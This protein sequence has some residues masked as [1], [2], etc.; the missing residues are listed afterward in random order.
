MKKVGLYVRVSTREQAEEG[1]SV[2]AQIDKLRLYCQSKDWMVVDEYVDG[3]YTGSNTD[4]PALK[5]LIF[6]VERKKINMVLVY[7]LDRLSRS[8]KDTLYLIEEV[9]KKNE[10]D[11]SSIQENFDTSTPLGMA[12]VGIL[13]VFAQL[14]RSQIQERMQLGKDAIAKQ[15]IYMRRSNKYPIGYDYVDDGLKV[16][17]YEAI[18][19][20]EIYRLF[21]DE[22]YTYERIIDAMSKYHTRYGKYKWRSSIEN[23]LTNPI[24]T[25]KFKYKGEVYQSTHEAIIDD[26]TFEKAQEILRIKK[27]RNEKNEKSPF[28]RSTLLSGLLYCGNCGARLGGSSRKKYVKYKVYDRESIYICYSRTHN[29]YMKKADSCDMRVLVRDELDE[30][31]WNEITSLNLKI[32]EGK[33]IFEKN[34]NTAEIEIIEKEIASIDGK[35]LKLMDLYSIGSIPS[36]LLANK[37]QKLNDEKEELIEKISELNNTPDVDQEEI[38]NTIQ[39]AEYIRDHGTL[40]EKRSLIAALIERITVYQDHIHIKYRFV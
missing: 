32:S 27:E 30:I 13:S 15:G 31:V 11:F 18:Q 36:D 19:V 20:R 28:A 3:G 37:I 21:V 25:G 40:A 1:Y 23:I 9:F 29:R 4:R 34:D 16:I 22:G 5:K 39:S 24:Y 38:I 17:D 6:D 7:K 12:M 26:E 8:Q 2:G 14:E 33:S 10:V 35:I